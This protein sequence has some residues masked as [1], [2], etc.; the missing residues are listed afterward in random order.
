MSSALRLPRAAR[1]F[2]TLL[3]T[4][5]C[6]T[7]L[8]RELGAGAPP[9]EAAWSPD[10]RPVSETCRALAK[11]PALTAP[12]AKIAYQ[13]V[14]TAKLR[15][16]VDI[17]PHA[18]KIY[19]VEKDGAIR[20][21]ADDGKTAPLV[22]DLSKELIVGY[23]WGLMSFAF[24][25][26]F[27]NNGY[28]Y[29]TFNV[30]Y[31]TLPLPEDV[32]FQ[33]VLARFESKDGGLTIDPTTEK[34]L[35]VRNQPNINHGGNKVAFGNDG[36]LYYSVGDGSKTWEEGQKK[37]SLFGK[38]L[39]FDVDHGDPYA[40]PPTNPF[41]A[42]GGAPEVY[43][44][45]LRNPWRFNFDRVNGDL[46]LG[47]VGNTHFEEIDRIVLGGNYGWSV[48]EGRMCNLAPTCD[49]TGFIDPVVTHEH[50]GTP[51]GANAIIGGV[52]YRGSALPE[53][54]GKYV[55][56]DY[57]SSNWWMI[58]PTPGAKVTPIRLERGLERV[59]PVS[60]DLDEKGE[61][62]FATH[63]GKVFRIVPPPAD[64]GPEMPAALSATGCVDKTDPTKPAAGL[65]PYDVNVPQWNDGAVADRYLSVP[66][67]TT[68]AVGERGV[69]D[70]PPGS[71]AMRTF[72][73]ESKLVE[74]QLLLHRPD[75]SWDAYTY[76]WSSD[77]KDAQL[78]TKETTIALPN[79]ATHTVKPAECTGCHTGHVTR[80]LEAG[81]L[82]RGGVDPKVPHTSLATLAHVGLLAAPIAPESYDVFPQLTGY[83]T[84]ERRSRAYLHANCS[85]CHDGQDKT[86]LDL[87][88]T[89][90]RP[91][92]R[93]C[94]ILS[95][96]RSTG[97]D[98][99]PPIGPKTPD[100][101]ALR[102]LSAWVA[103]FRPCP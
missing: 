22:M 25:P 14:T 7:Q 31:P 74:T 95:T 100:A 93:A 23:D 66:A 55:Y 94:A 16:L 26:D 36:Y 53:L 61:I 2:L 6:S 32:V 33:S 20:Y 43:A 27:A 28:V 35:L 56:G 67:G 17:V 87:R 10:T 50:D 90:P 11:S 71:V 47:D 42:G 49:P 3:V 84:D 79:A 102:A 37:D 40:I 85:G 44:Y 76:A 75:A 83:D 58:D 19:V 72:K 5:A 89:A 63:E 80:G 12:E 1:L 46:W 91:D 64:A 81:Q 78:V 24:H 9:E 51:D 92:D 8:P 34:R 96:M 98:H 57:G 103:G 73:K 4:G 29:A 82:E 68:I 48:M 77:Q 99:Q 39:R 70:L 41:A 30:P 88:W 86:K 97:P 69:L 62:I 60:I 21:L 101:T 13:Q 38:V 18:G 52:V 59:G 54:K 65:F 15:E 45:G